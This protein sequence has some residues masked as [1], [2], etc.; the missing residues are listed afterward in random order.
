M[1]SSAHRS[2]RRV[3]SL[4]EMP[5]SVTFLLSPP[6]THL[7]AYALA[8]KRLS[9]ALPP[10]PPFTFP[11]TFALS[12]SSP[13]RSPSRRRS[14][15]PPVALALSRLSA[16]HPVAFALS[17][18]SPLQS[19][20]PSG[21]SL[22][23]L[24]LTSSPPIGIALTFL[25]PLAIA[26]TFLLSPPIRRSPPLPS[27]PV[28]RLLSPPI[29]SFASSPLPS[30]RS[31]PLPSHPVVRLLSPPIP[32]FASSP[33]PSRRSP[34]L[35]SHPVVRLLS[36][37]IPSF[38]SSPL[39]SRRSPPLPSHPVV[40]L[41]SRLSSSLPFLPVAPPLS[42]RCPLFLS[43]SPSISFY[44]F[45]FRRSGSSK[46]IVFSSS[47]GGDSGTTLNCS[48]NPPIHRGSHPADVFFRAST[49]RLSGAIP[50][51]CVPPHLP[52]LSCSTRIKEQPS[53]LRLWRRATHRASHTSETSSRL[54]RKERV[55]GSEGRS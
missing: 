52:S 6:S 32:S 33:L 15:L 42:P 41:L 16:L 48:A 54:G 21:R 12:L 28:V 46:T 34:P 47:S 9:P 39:P 10:S 29:P 30:R 3:S 27:H 24:S 4:P 13:A 5:P 1:H 23:L 36:P 43:L 31:P 7:V 19:P 22:H 25:P 38:V 45:R 8:L 50:R 37:P 44:P 26:L 11:V 53:L 49:H 20:L 14:A 40:R 17:I 2:P 55:R 18:P 51:I 35:P